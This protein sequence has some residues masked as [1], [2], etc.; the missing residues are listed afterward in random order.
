[1][2][3]HECPT[4]VAAQSQSTEMSPQGSN[5]TV[6]PEDSE[7]GQDGLENMGMESETNTA[8][9][10]GSVGLSKESRERG[11]QE[12][13]WGCGVMEFNDHHYAL[14]VLNI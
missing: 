6:L 3:G 13:E 7:T 10:R 5:V 4:K 1:M 8:E 2:E 14:H 12:R 11:M 9:M